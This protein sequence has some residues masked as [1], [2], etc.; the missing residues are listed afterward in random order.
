MSGVATENAW[1][2]PQGGGLIVGWIEQGDWMDYSYNAPA[3]GAYGIKMRVASP[4][5]GAQLQIRN[6]SGTVLQTVSL[7]NT[8][9]WQTWT[10]ITTSI[11]LT[12]G[13]QTLRLYAS[14]ATGWNINWWEL[15]SPAGTLLSAAA[16]TEGIMTTEQ[17]PASA[18]S[19]DIFPNPVSDR[20]ALQVNNALTG[21]LKVEVLNTGGAVQKQ[22]ALQKTVASPS[23]FYLSIGELPAASYFIK[24]T[25][26]GWTPSKQIIKQ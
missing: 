8:G 19:I 10:T 17:G 26:E 7:P 13:T 15:T 23:Q 6:S 25:M 9:G 20:F 3:T 5:T 1:G 21:S 4:L 18:P 16:P 12:A 11:N 24:V 2:D 22:F 14:N